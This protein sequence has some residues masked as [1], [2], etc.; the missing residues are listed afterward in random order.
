MIIDPGMDAA[1]GVAELIMEHRLK[2]VA[3]ML[4]HGH[5]DHMFSVTPLCRSYASACWVHSEDRVLLTDP[6]QAMGLETRLLLERLTGRPSSFVEPKDVH[7]LQ[8]RDRC[9]RR[10]TELPGDSR[11]WPHARLDDVPDCISGEPRYRVGG[12]QWRRLVRGLD[13]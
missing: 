2:P 13:R 4:T 11:A 5:L 3:V 10:R 1:D 6:L 9:R 7:E 12:F 8:R